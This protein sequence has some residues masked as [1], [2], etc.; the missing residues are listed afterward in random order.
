V[1]RTN[2]ST[3]GLRRAYHTGAVNQVRRKEKAG[4]AQEAVETPQPC[5]VA[6]PNTPYPSKRLIGRSTSY[7]VS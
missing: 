2:V 5:K 6:F 7:S 3:K 1:L 4:T